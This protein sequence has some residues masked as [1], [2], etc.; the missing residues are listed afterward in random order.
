MRVVLDGR[1]TADEFGLV[2]EDGL[3]K[4]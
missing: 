3:A 4:A 2:P 1:I